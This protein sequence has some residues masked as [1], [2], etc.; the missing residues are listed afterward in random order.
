MA[1]DNFSA[2]LDAEQVARFDE[3]FDRHYQRQLKKLLE[4]YPDEKSLDVDFEALTRFDPSLADKLLEEPD[5]M[6]A[7]AAEAIV[8]RREATAVEGVEFKPN[9]RV[10][11]LPEACRVQVLELGAAQI[12]KLYG[13]EGVVSS[14]SEI[15]PRVIKAAWR[16]KHCDADNVLYTKKTEPVSPPFACANPACGRGNFELREDAS[17]FVNMQRA[18]MQDPVEKMRGN[19]PSVNAELWLEDDLVNQIAPGDKI[20]VTGMLRL[21]PVQQGKGRSSVYAKFFEVNHIHEIELDFEEL[22]VTRE[23]EAEILKLSQDPRLRDKIIASI[24]PSVWGYTELKLAIALQ[25]FG[26]TPGKIQPDGKHIRSDMHVLMIGDPG[27]AK[28]TVLE[29]VRDLAPKCIIVSGGGVSGVGLTA[30]AEKDAITEGWV[31]KAG[32]MVLANGGLVGIDEMDKMDE[33]DRG[34]IHQAMEQQRISIAKAGIVTEFRTKTAVLGAANPKMGRFDPNTPIASQFA[35]SP[36][37]LS[38][39]DL[40]FPMKDV[41]D[42]SRDRQVAEHI[43]EGHR[44]AAAHSKPQGESPIVPVIRADLLRKYI[45]YARRNVAPEL[46]VEAAG[47]VKEYYVEL[48]KLGKEQNTFPITARQIEGLIRLSE[49]HAK[50]RL[51]PL[52]EAQDAQSAVDLLDFVL[53]G[54]FF[55]RET[56]RID[57]DI[58]AIGQPK[59]KLDKVR[60]VLGIINSLEK[61]MDLVAED[62]VVRE[63]ASLGMDE[64]YA[65]KLVDELKRQGDLYSPKPGYLKQARSREY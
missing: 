37:L 39:F 52:V 26:G 32:A 65:R 30:S 18:Q 62:D 33:E 14:I 45:A 25:L 9:V 38:R 12:D 44:Y 22:E 20:V 29:Y 40:I 56:G 1:E 6:V 43:L 54:V 42:E 48:R 23:E 11:N 8:Q 58:I 41:L 28:S 31:L 16:C 13:I 17:T 24:A 15:K 57:S 60:S 27:T 2:K 5:A 49:A 34:A 3:F 46:T 64:S 4:K 50:M 19:M 51:S 61:E 7:C 63:A 10:F 59:S 47:K 55:D 21:K 36:A 35:L 53:R